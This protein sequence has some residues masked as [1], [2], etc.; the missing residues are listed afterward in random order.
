M[1]L[2]QLFHPPHLP[3]TQRGLSLQVNQCGMVSNDRG[4][5]T[6]N[7]RSPALTS[8]YDRVLL[9]LMGRVVGLSLGQLPAEVCD[10]L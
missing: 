2:R 10:G 8:Q 6:V 4:P 5:L 7:V 9:A 3:L 1:K